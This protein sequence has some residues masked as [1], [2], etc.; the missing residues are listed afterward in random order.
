MS[1][2][3][4]QEL[5]V[6]ALA[7]Y[8]M[9]CGIFCEHCHHTQRCVAPTNENFRERFCHLCRAGLAG[10]LQAYR[11]EKHMG[12]LDGTPDERSRFMSTG[13]VYNVNPKRYEYVDVKTARSYYFEHIT[14]LSQPYNQWHVVQ[15]VL[16]QMGMKYFKYLQYTL[17]LCE[18]TVGIVQF[19]ERVNISKLKIAFNDVQCNISLLQHVHLPMV[20]PHLRIWLL[21]RHHDLPE[22]M[23]QER[24]RFAL[25]GRNR[26]LED[27]M[28]PYEELIKTFLRSLPFT[29][30]SHFKGGREICDYANALNRLPVDGI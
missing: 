27:D 22:S 19:D 23:I 5:E 13:V 26:N 3:S 7:Q 12:L 8:T 20:I 18:K 14:P 25:G 17:Q 9:S 21:C 16:T 1:L 10:T 2:M 24:G 4:D 28:T 30:C 11:A 6:K 29:V 15:E